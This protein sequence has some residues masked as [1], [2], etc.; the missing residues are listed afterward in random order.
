MPAN[1]LARRLIGFAG[2]TLAAMSISL[3]FAEIRDCGWQLSGVCPLSTMGYD[4]SAEALE[5]RQPRE[6]D[7][8]GEPV[9]QT[10]TELEA[11]GLSLIV[12]LSPGQSCMDTGPQ[13]VLYTIDL[14]VSLAPQTA[15]NLY[16]RGG[17]VF[18]SP[19]LEHELMTDTEL[20]R[21]RAQLNCPR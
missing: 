14:A 20:R 11:A 10:V 21:A 12:H 2:L 6:V 18:D 8:V 17:R 9:D 5:L 4:L 16:V 3:A 1:A 19:V 15:E 13:A 7:V